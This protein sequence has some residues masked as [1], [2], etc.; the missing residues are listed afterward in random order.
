MRAN[1]NL[2]PWIDA[3]VLGSAEVYTAAVVG[4]LVAAEPAAADVVLAVALAVWAPQ[5]GHACIDLATIAADVEVELARAT[6]DANGNIGERPPLPWPEPQAW[7]AALMCSAAVRVV[8]AVDVEAV[9]DDRP[10]VLFGRRLYTQRQWVDECAVAVAIR[11]RSAGEREPTI[12]APAPLTVIVG[13]PGTGKTHTVAGLLAA[14]VA[15]GQPVRIG[16]AA[17]TGK[18]ASRL[19]EAIAATARRAE[20]LDAAS[21][22]RLAELRAVTVHRLLGPRP[23]HRTRFRHDAAVP[24]E[25][26]LLVVDET[27]MLALP[28]TA[29]LLEAVPDECRLVLVGDPDQLTSIEVGAVLGDIVRAAEAGSPL[30]S[31]VIR[32]TSQHRTGRDSPI[33]PLAEAIRRG[34][35]EATIDLLRGGAARHL[36]FVEVPDGDVTGAAIEAVLEAV[37]PAYAAGRDAAARR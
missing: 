34:D 15:S 30:E 33:G 11:R 19:S 28:L 10:T 16:L 21:A 12:S 37:G 17:P 29:R 22:A 13:G 14:E 8:S 24:L 7:Q 1:A 6:A 4:E 3:G 26:D 32:L 25:L 27:S 18:A 5:H 36:Q 9:L 31:R 23:D 2:Q 35:A 20:N